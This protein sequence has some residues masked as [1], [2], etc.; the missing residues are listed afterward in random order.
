MHTD[1]DQQTTRRPRLRAG[2]APCQ[3]PV[4]GRRAGVRFS[5]RL[6]YIGDVY[7]DI[8][9]GVGK[10][11]DAVGVAVIAVGLIYAIVVVFRRPATG[12]VDRYREFRQTVGR[13]I[14]LGLELLVAG[15]IIRTVAVSPSFVSVGVLAIIVVIR[16]FLSFTLEL[17]LTGRWPWSKRP[18]T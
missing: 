6:G 5:S 10:T 9:D 11:I 12:P 7:E 4:C 17:E 2:A 8:I 16:T 13:S 18:P 3:R 14:L 1:R 15:D